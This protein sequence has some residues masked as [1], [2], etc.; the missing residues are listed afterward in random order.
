[1]VKELTVENFGLIR[2]ASVEFGPGFNAITGESGAGKSLL[3]NAIGFLMGA[4]VSDPAGPFGEVVRVR[5]SF[6]VALDHP[7]WLVLEGYGIEPDE[8]LIL[9]RELGRDGRSAYR[10]Q[11]QIVPAQAV[12]RVA[13]HL[14]EITAQHQSIKIADP[15]TLLSWLDRIG[16]L[17][18]LAWNVAQAYREWRQAENALAT[19][20]RTAGDSEEWDRLRA[21]VD[22]IGN[23]QILPNEDESLNEELARLRQG[24]RLVEGYQTIDRYLNQDDVGVIPGIAHVVRILDGLMRMDPGL[25]PAMQMLDQVSLLLSEMQWTLSEWYQNLNLDPAHLEQI[26]QRAD[27]LARIKRKYGPQLSDVLELLNASTKRL[28][29]VDNITWELNKWTK[30]ATA[31]FQ[32]YRQLAEQLS[33]QRQTLA[34]AVAT[35]VEQL[36]SQMEMLGAVVKFV[37]SPVSPRDTGVDMV[38]CQ[39]AANPGQD[40]RPLAKVA[41]GGELSRV[42]LAMAVVEGRASTATL[43]LDELDTGLGG[44]SA[45][46]VGQLLSRLGHTRQVVAVSHQPTVAARAKT[47]I[48]VFKVIKNA[49]AESSVAS[50]DMAGRPG[51]VARMLSGNPDAVALEHAR[52][53]LAQE[54]EGA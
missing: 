4:R 28:A 44:I 54:V 36:L 14:V 48:K 11:G 19:I 25:Q 12:R 51:E 45:Q 26:E 49:M 1:M 30:I 38:E 37:I 27:L 32:D 53:L 34:Q 10:A 9:Q 8:W 33:F 46:Q 50:L 43:V 41:S 29:E 39:F 47:H 24:Q 52:Q 18:Q 5:A 15:D 16:N 31:R 7:L 21:L 40:P 42:A 35:E 2:S 6:E 20:Q 23:A 22:E 17:E 3:L 13:L